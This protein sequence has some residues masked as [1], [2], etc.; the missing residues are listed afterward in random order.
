MALSKQDRDEIKDLVKE[1]VNRKIEKLDAKVTQHLEEVKPFLV[2]FAGAKVIG[3]T[4]KWIA[5][6]LIA[7]GASIAILTQIN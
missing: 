6:V 5:G 4:I 2:G 3:N 7:I 1:V